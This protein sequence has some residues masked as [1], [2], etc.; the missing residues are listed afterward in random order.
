VQHEKSGREAAASSAGSKKGFMVDGSG[1]VFA[2]S[3]VRMRRIRAVAGYPPAMVD[4][5]D[6][7]RCPLCGE[8]NQCAM[9]C[10]ASTSVTEAAAS[11]CWCFRVTIPQEVLDRIP[12]PARNVACI[13]ARCA[14]AGGAPK[15]SG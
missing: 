2:R 11:A 3:R 13:C 15:V 7:A 10:A 4:P 14:A 8:A 12:A 6:P 1:A 9:A 5:V